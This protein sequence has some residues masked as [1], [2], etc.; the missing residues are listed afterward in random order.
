MTL[1]RSLTKAPNS[2]KV[3]Q[4]EHQGA[5]CVGDLQGAIAGG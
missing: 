2:V 5:T 4:E 3:A 1:G